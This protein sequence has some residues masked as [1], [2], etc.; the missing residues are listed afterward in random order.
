MRASSASVACRS[1]CSLSG[2][3]APSTMASTWRL[4]YLKRIVNQYIT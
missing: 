1:A 4:P 2:S 3:S